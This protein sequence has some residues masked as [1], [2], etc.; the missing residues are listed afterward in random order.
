L[1]IRQGI[2]RAIADKSR[3]IRLPIHITEKLNK[4]KKAQR[5]LSQGLGRAA[6]ISELAQELELTPEQVREY[7][8][9]SRQTFSLDVK[10]GDNQ[11][12]E[13]RDLLEDDG[14]SPEDYATQS[15]LRNDLEQM[16]AHLTP[17]QQEVLSLRFGLADGQALTLSKIGERLNLSRERVRQI[18]REAVAKLRRQSVKLRGYLAS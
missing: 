4:I 16:M 12:T 10:V 9:R 11:D 8:E 13:L 14:P 1:W 17:Q 15:A 3:V 18:Q 7:L 5:K 2:T 6:T